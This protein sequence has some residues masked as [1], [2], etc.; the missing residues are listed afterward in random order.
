VVAFEVAGVKLKAETRPDLFSPKDLDRGSRLLL[1]QLS[2]AE[3]AS[4]LDWGCGWGAMTLWLA[5]HRP[6]AQVLALDS[7][8][9]AIKSTEANVQLNALT[10]VEVVISHGYE[11]ISTEQ[12]FDLIISNPPTH[13][14]R[15]VVETMIAESKQRLAK[16]GR[17]IIVVE[18]R[19]KPWVQRALTAE[20]GACEVLA[21]SSKHVVILA[22]K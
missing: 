9:G 21:R 14:G 5:K 17:L 20:F 22:L 6:S 2:D 15:E 3:Y 8:I 13:R 10:N 1:E 4:A 18:A 7:D 16:G 11:D 19:L 12:S